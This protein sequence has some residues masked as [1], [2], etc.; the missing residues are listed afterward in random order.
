M[1]RKIIL[2]IALLGSIAAFAHEGHDNVPGAIKANHGGTV[3]P[4]KEIN[5]EYVVSGTEVKLYPA[6]HEGADLTA[7]EVKL[8]VKSKLPS[9]KPQQI[10]IDSKDGTFIAKVDFKNAYRVEVNVDAEVKGKKSSFK[11]QVE[12]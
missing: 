3:M 6:S 4:G 10:K 7:S 9:G 2:S 1:F 8:V 11:F 5:L 12:K